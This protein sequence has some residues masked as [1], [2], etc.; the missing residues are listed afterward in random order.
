MA[1]KGLT[2]GVKA[3][4]FELPATNNQKIRLS[5]FSKQPVIITFLRGTW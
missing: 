3:P 5:D 2:V 4:E 1:N